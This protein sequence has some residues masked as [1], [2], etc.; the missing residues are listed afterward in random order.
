MY[1][2]NLMRCK[3]TTYTLILQIYKENNCSLIIQVLFTESYT[4]Q[5][6]PFR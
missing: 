2:F 5:S 4:L 6:I 1:F 3:V